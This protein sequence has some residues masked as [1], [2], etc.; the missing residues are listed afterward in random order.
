MSFKKSVGWANISCNPIK[1]R[2]KG[3]CW[4]CYYSAKGKMLD[5][6]KHNPEIRLQLSAFDALPK[7]A[8]K[9]VF[10][11]STH[12]LFGSWISENWRDLI[13]HHIEKFSHHTFQVLTKFPLNIDREMPDNVWL[14][15]SC[16]GGKN[17]FLR[18]I[19][20]EH[21]KAKVR[22]AS[23][24][25]LLRR[26]IIGADF[27]DWIIVGRLTGYGKKYDPKKEWI[28]EIITQPVIGNVPIFLKDNLQK[29][30]NAPLIQEYP[31]E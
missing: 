5:F 6:R 30:W 23:Y 18:L 3:G 9:R 13:F 12:D 20:L 2:C 26:S 27:L 14:G 4:Y 16:D 8:S 24:E 11:C 15:V 7:K 17:D 31:K 29:I 1:G 19:T 10:L 22:F 25:P 28:E 21:L